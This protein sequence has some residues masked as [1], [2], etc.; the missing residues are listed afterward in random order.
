MARKE[1]PKSRW[2][3]RRTAAGI[4]HNRNARLVKIEMGNRFANARER[5]TH[6]RRMKRSGNVQTDRLLAVRSR[7]VLGS[8]D[9]FY[10]TGQN[11]LRRAVLVRDFQHVAASGDLA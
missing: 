10:R 1:I 9:R 2:F 8:F 5:R 3:I 7:E 4:R 6:Q 11:D